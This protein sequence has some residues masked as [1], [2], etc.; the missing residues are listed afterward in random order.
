[1]K[2]SYAILPDYPLSVSLTSIRLLMILE[3]GD[4]ARLGYQPGG[5]GSNG[6]ISL[7]ESLG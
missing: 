4:Q 6:P 3:S 7:V 1:M 2:F 5:V